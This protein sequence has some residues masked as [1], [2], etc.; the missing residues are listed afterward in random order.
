MFCSPPATFLF[1]RHYLLRS[2]QCFALER[3][4]VGSRFAKRRFKG[5]VDRIVGDAERLHGLRLLIRAAR[6]ARQVAR[7]GEGRLIDGAISGT[8]IG[9][10]WS[11]FENTGICAA[12]QVNPS[13]QTGKGR[14][15]QD[16]FNAAM[17]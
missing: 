12:S 6:H 2:R 4:G 7:S 5:L 9:R 3:R 17:R 8:L 11:G 10:A 16:E 14:A 1:Q 13:S 15:E